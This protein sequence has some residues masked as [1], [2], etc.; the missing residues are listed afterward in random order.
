MDNRILLIDDDAACAKIIE[1][2]LADAR[3][4]P[5]HVERVRN[6]SD[7]IERLRGQGISA[8]L[9]NLFLP[10][11]KGMQ[12]FD[13]LFA[14]TPHV[15][16]L[17]LSGA[18]DEALARQAV[19]CGAQDYLLKSHVDSHWLPRALRYAI[20]R[21]AT[22][23][24]LFAEKERAQVTLN[25]I[26]DAV[27]ST[28]VAGNVTYL[29]LV[30]ER[31]TGWS[32]EQA[33]G[34]PLADVFQ[35]VD[36]ATRTPVRDPMEL[37]VRQNQTVGLGP[38]CILIRRDGFESLIEDSTAPIHD[39]QGRLTG[40]VIVFHD[41]SQARAMVLRMSYLAQ[42]DYLTNLPN[43]VLL[44]DRL[45][46]TIVRAQRH[47]N[48]AAVLFL[49][50]DR[51]KHIND[52]LGHTIGDKVLQSVAERLVSCVRSSDTVSRQGGDEF[53]ILLREIQCMEDVA[54]RAKK[55]L[56]TLVA[57]HHITGHKLHITAS[58]GI[59][60]YP[61]D[62]QDAEM[63]V[64]SADTA[65]YHAKDNGR[66]N[67]Q[68]FRQDMNNRVVERQSLED[69]LRDALERQEL[70]LHYQPKINLETGAITGAEALIRWQHPSRGLVLP[71][72]FVPIAEDCGLI[73]P[74]GRWALREAC[75]QARAWL[76]AGRPISVAVNISAVEF[77]DKDFLE[78]VRAALESARLEPRYLELE[79]TES[80][81]MQNTVSTATAIRALQTM[82][83]QL[84][85]DDFGTGY[86]SFTYLRLFPTDTLK[87]DQSFVR[88]I[89]VDPNDAAIVGAI[90]SMCRSLKR[91]IVAE[92]VETRAQFEFLRAQG[93]GEGQGHYFSPPVV[94]AEFAKLL[95]TG[96][97][98][99]RPELTAELFMSGGEAL[100]HRAR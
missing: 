71:E 38:N 1:A 96:I 11:S 10:D 15:P 61:E 27:L 24:A 45:T 48:L 31:M 53:V 82:G 54:A 80:I 92:G 47:A 14:A 74:I 9:L 69:S 39:R 65:M 8:V 57:P 40:A 62:G 26:G 58:I 4:I 23:E 7:G 86:S 49:D 99:S 78:T 36:G 13:T 44:N 18:D 2:A 93:C 37:A 25:S 68:F 12:T 30:A 42:H 19:R 97:F 16:I 81:L 85:I 35:I 56:T 22:E 60:L 66:N 63:L 28:D 33:C 76:D 59:S 70:I 72:H 91:R 34:R 98:T 73:V 32:R 84:A 90:I 64:K 29:N 41:V 55:I 89:T 17:V 67:Y 94:A 21:K 3:D 100:D 52:S 83:V 79:L 87:I 51:F 5:F 50:L 77:R 46:Q 88:Y 43:R 20:G 95:R 6:L 75:R